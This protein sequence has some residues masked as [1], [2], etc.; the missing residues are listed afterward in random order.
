MMDSPDH[1]FSYSG[2]SVRGARKMLLVIALGALAL[3]AA[4]SPS[5]PNGPGQSSS[6]LIDAA[7]RA[8]ALAFDK[9][10]ADLGVVPA[11]QR[12][13]YTF[14]VINKGQQVLQVGPVRLRVEQGCDAAETVTGKDTVKPGETVL[15]PIRLGP[16]RELGPHLLWIDVSS[17]D[18]AR[19]VS[20]V[21]LRFQVAEDGAASATGPRLRVDKEVIDIGIV[22]F[23]W[24]LYEQFTLRNEGDAPLVI[25]GTPELRVEGGC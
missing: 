16:H 8:P 4:C 7:E 15:L 23:D 12:G 17:N 18:P 10:E 20:G 22:P 24:P 13:I 14:M 1:E 9:L 2:D 19:P 5:G 6:T 11:S 21:A 3:A 25:Q